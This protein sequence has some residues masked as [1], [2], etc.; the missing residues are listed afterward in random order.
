MS[1]PP[2]NGK[3]FAA[4]AG[5]VLVIFTAFS[6]MQT[7]ILEIQR[8]VRGRTGGLAHAQALTSSELGETREFVELAL[9]DSTIGLRRTKEDLE[10]SVFRLEA[11]RDRLLE[12]VERLSLELG[13]S[14]ESRCEEETEELQSLRGVIQENT[15]RIETLSAPLRRDSLS[16]KRAMIFPTIQLRGN[17]TVGS[18]V[19]IYSEPQPGDSEPPIYTTFA[20]TACHVVQE[21]VGSE[22]SRGQ[23]V[24]QIRVM[25]EDDFEPAGDIKAC[26]VLFDTDRDTALLRL[27]TT[28]RFPYLARLM[29]RADLERL[30]VFCPA[31]AVGCPLGNYPMPTLGEV[32]SL[33]K[34]V[35]KQTFWMLNA[36]TFFGNSGGGVYLAPDYQLIGVS[37][38]IYTYGKRNPTVVPHMGLF[39]PLETI[40]Q[41]LAGERYEFLLERRPVPSELRDS[42]VFT[43]DPETTPPGGGRVEA[44]VEATADKEEA[45][46]GGG[47]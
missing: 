27:N 43:A 12:A 47:S 40:Y 20:L 7:Q 28:R 31:Y 33:Q 34:R 8:E 13:A 5:K 45:T 46:D 25:G 41:W 30:D 11:E 26:L 16:M 1:E 23:D 4:E 38:M 36:P 15:C 3:S 6:L 19:L 42:L 10:R 29:P 35:G 9:E 44:S 17:G 37:S 21:L 32:S 14:I 39:V 18:G 22:I 24:G 2:S